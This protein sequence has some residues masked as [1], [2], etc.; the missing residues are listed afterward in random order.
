MLLAIDIGNTNIVFGVSDNGKWLNHWRIQ[1]DHKKTADEY[2]V[3]FRSLLS[4]GKIC[5]SDVNN[6]ILS[7]VVPSLV[8]PFTEMLPGLFDGTK[9]TVVGP[10]IYP[11]LPIKILNPYQI[12]ADL[13]ANAVAAYRKFGKLTTVIDFGTALTF[14]TIGKNGEIKG[15]AI[16]PGLQT[17]VAALAGGTAQLPHVHLTPPPSVLGENTVHAIQSG[18]VYGFTGLVDSMIER[19]QQELGEELTVVATGGL[20]SVIAPLTKNIKNVELLLTLDGL[21]EICRIVC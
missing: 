14:T 7:S 9:I 15:V 10:D 11:K 20:S 8:R 2:E 17:A 12:G 4:A 21:V 18:I 6:I 1:T 5:R 16:A 3:I 13:V 19:T